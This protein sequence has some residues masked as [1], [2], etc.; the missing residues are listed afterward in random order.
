MEDALEEIG[1]LANSANRVRVLD[2]LGGAPASRREL[3]EE[4]GVPRS[5]AARVLDDAEA[6]GWVD[7]EG[8]RY[9]LR[10]AGAARISEFRTYVA[11]T[12]GMQHLGETID[13]LPE[14]ARSLDF[15]HLRDATITTP[16]EANPTA[17][18][19]RGMEL[20]RDAEEYRGLTRNSLPQYMTELRDRV[21]QGELDFQ[22]V[23]E[24]GF[25]DVLRG[26]PERA[27]LWHDVADRMWLYDGHVPV[28]MHVVDG[29]ALV[30]LCDEDSDGEEVIV[31]GLLESDHPEVVS[32]A[33]SLYEEYRGESEPMDPGILP[34]E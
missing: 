2:A 26:D 27:A 28:N 31:K 33:E 11:T 1:F 15:R 16:T 7:S 20:V 5:T 3:Q 9:R 30:W 4:T 18:F 22:G 19:D 21:V 12:E 10:P 24:R 23:V 29:T 34:P 25:V 6:R 14:P 8:S 17:Q 13:W 32:W